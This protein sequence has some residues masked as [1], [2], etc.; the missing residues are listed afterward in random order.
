MIVV[1]KTELPS[2][3]GF[4]PAR[5]EESPAVTIPSCLPR[6]S[7]RSRSARCCAAVLVL[8]AVV[9][10]CSSDDE[11]SNGD[12]DIVGA[13]SLLVDIREATAAAGGMRLEGSLTTA[14]GSTGDV[15]ISVAREPARGDVDLGVSSAAPGATG[16]TAMRWQGDD[17]WMRLD[18]EAAVLEPGRPWRTGLYTDETAVITVPYDP[19]LLLDT[20]IDSITEVV[21]PVG[22]DDEAGGLRRFDIRLI[23]VPA[24][25][26]G[27]GQGSLWVDDDDRVARIRLEGRGRTLELEVVERGIDVTVAAPA[28]DEIGTPGGPPAV[29]EGPWQLV[30]EGRDEATGVTWMLERAPGSRGTVCWRLTA[31][32]A[33]Q[34]APSTG[35]QGE[36][37][38]EPFGPDDDPDDQVLFLVDASGATPYDALV[39]LVPAGSQAT[40][41]DLDGITH[42]VEVDEDGFATWFAGAEVFAVAMEVILPDGTELQCG[43]GIITEYADL[44]LIPADQRS[45]LRDEVWSCL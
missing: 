45:S 32:P 12:D 42:A 23:G 40:A 39:L 24:A 4:G 19:V 14:D 22:V 17:L 10:G 16:H 35:P 44:D 13:N 27:F 36:V 1:A 38:R 28:D 37:C 34:S 2:R 15:T 3:G 43:P 7:W 18:D 6:R 21:E 11:S 31:D 25:A 30:R 26:I 20:L 5:V 33:L 8:A 9:A 41:V 29:A